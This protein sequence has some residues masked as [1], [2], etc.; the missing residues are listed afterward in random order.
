MHNNHIIT[1]KSPFCCRLNHV[2][3]SITEC[4]NT[5]DVLQVQEVRYCTFSK[6]VD[7][8]SSQLKSQGIEVTEFTNPIAQYNAS[9]ID[10][11][12]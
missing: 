8:S 10:N 2:V 1:I 4:E 7:L 12:I 3:R 6:K 11:K 5:L 9:D